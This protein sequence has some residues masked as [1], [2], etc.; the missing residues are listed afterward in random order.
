MLQLL[1][2]HRAGPKMMMFCN[3][4]LFYD[5]GVDDETEKLSNIEN[6]LF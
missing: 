2:H 6:A 1:L 5:C 3:K 4:K